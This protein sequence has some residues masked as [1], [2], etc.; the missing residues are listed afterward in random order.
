MEKSVGRLRKKAIA[1]FFRVDFVVMS[2][3]IT[4]FTRF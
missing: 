4:I 3:I 2:K 1:Q